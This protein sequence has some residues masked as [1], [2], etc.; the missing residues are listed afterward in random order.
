VLRRPQREEQGPICRG[1]NPPNDFFDPRVSVDLSSWGSILTTV[2]VLH[3][4]AC[5]ASTLLPVGDPPP[6]CFFFTNRSLGRREAGAYRGGR[7][8]TAFFSGNS[9]KYAEVGK[10]AIFDGNRR[11]YS[12]TVRDRPVVM[13]H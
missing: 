4:S 2:L 6:Q 7:P 5:G 9:V 1:L 8:P 11:L 13:D 3:V 12:E 10:I